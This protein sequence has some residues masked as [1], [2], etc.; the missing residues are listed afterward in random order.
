MM[1]CSSIKEISKVVHCLHFS[2]MNVTGFSHQVGGHFGIFT[3]GG[4]ICKPLN[5]K[6]L[7]FYK[8]IGD[9]FAPFTAH[10]CGTVSIQPRNSRDDG[11]ILTTDRPVLCHQNATSS[12]KQLIFRLNKNGR[13]ESDQHFNE[14]AK[15]CQTRSV[16]KLL[17]GYAL[18]L[19]LE[20]TVSRFS[21]PSVM[22]LK[23]GT[24]QYGDDATDQKRQSQ[25]NKC[26]ESTSAS[27]GIRLV[28]MQLYREEIGTYVYVNKY[29][30]RQMNCEMFRETLA[31]YFINAGKIRSTALLKKLTTLRK[32]LAEADGYRFFSSSLLIAF[33]G[34]KRDDTSIDLRMIDFAHSTCSTL[35]DDIRYIG[36]DDGYLL[37]L[38]FLISSLMDIINR[39][40]T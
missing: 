35:L 27:I 6:E 40:L 39:C 29:A 14:W 21:R 5:S 11:L 36:P 16:Q 26:R 32:R 15:Q 31:E 3:C 4:H 17:K 1:T 34:K 12:E 9:R 20:N 19:L 38:D 22:D 24:R 33:D 18:F 37:G 28:G 13:V 7:A 2:E 25:T 30:G 23:M 8:E 10:C